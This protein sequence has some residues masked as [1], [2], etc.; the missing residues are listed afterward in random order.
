MDSIGLKKH[1]EY[2]KYTKCME[3]YD[4][5]NQSIDQDSEL[6]RALSHNHDFKEKFLPIV[7]AVRINSQSIQ[8]TFLHFQAFLTKIGELRTCGHARQYL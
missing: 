4:S 7:P 2:K 5:E 8:V 1:K 3:G 6:G